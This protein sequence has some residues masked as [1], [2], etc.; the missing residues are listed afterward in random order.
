MAENYIIAGLRQYQIIGGELS[1]QDGQAIDS[2]TIVVPVDAQ[3]YLSGGTEIS[4]IQRTDTGDTTLLTGRISRPMDSNGT[5]RIDIESYSAILNNVRGEEIYNN[6]TPEYIVQDLVT[7]YTDLTYASTAVS[8]ITIKQFVV[9][10]GGTILTF[11]QKLLELLGSWQLRGDFN[12]NIY[13]EPKVV[14]NSGKTLTVGTDCYVIKEWD[15]NPDTVVNKLILTGGNQ[16]F[17]TTQ[18]SFTATG[19]QTTKSLSYIPAST[20][21]ITDN[22]TELV[23]GITSNTSN[24]DYTVD[25]VNLLITFT[26]GLTVGHTIVV[27]YAYDVPIKLTADGP[28]D[29]ITKYGIRQ[30]KEDNQIVTTM[31]DARK[32]AESYFNERAYEVISNEVIVEDDYDITQGQ[33]ITVIDEFSNINQILQVQGKKYDFE[34]G[35]LTLTVGTRPFTN[36][37]LQKDIQ[38]RL[39]ALEQTKN[40]GTLTQKY[41]KT[42]EDINIKLKATT[43]N[44]ER[45]VKN[46]WIWGIS[47]WGV[48]K[49]G[50][51]REGDNFDQEGTYTLTDK[52]TITGAITIDT[53]RMKLDSTSTSPQIATYTAG[54]TYTNANG[55]I[56]TTIQKG[57]DTGSETIR[58]RYTDT[59]NYYEVKF[60]FQN[61]L[62]TINR[63]YLGVTTKIIETTKV[64][65]TIGEQFIIRYSGST[66]TIT[67]ETTLLLDTTTTAIPINNIFSEEINNSNYISPASTA[68]IDYVNHK[69]IF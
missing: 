5:L 38:Q 31:N 69:V 22:G 35:T 11:I 66:I 19:G 49:W 36:Y 32:F 37:H 13:F 63:I 44:Y 59:S 65:S 40:S 57:S 21:R 26:T 1:L 25:I 41:D 30:S 42:E 52:W 58:F 28:A 55:K 23:G 51:R 12:K 67:D 16:T 29:S 56:V 68:I 54:T 50:D 46:S 3:P 48:D 15:R 60:D 33:T 39:A 45:E 9:D 7:K 17:T 18:D 34:Q 8:G 43:Y 61:S 6:Q 20:F 64:Y 4:L 47:Q 53:K 62:I 10:D 27:S 2:G 24:P 14:N